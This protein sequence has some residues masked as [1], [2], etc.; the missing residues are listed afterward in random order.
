MIYASTMCDL[1]SPYSISHKKFKGRKTYI[2]TMIA[3]KRL[4]GAEL[5]LI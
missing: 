2:L 3:K 5:A 4:A 1:V